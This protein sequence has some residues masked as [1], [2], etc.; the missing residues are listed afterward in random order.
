MVS[1]DGLDQPVKQILYEFMQQGYDFHQLKSM[2]FLAVPSCAFA[3]EL[4]FWNQKS[5]ILWQCHVVAISSNFFWNLYEQW[6]IGYM[7]LYFFS[8]CMV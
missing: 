2:E 6:F 4:W 7:Y 5:L 1:D 3:C 8:P